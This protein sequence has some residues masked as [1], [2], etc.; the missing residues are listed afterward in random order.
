MKYTAVLIA[1]F[2]C[3]MLLLF[4]Q[5]AMKA[6][7]D[8]LN[9]WWGTLLPTLFPFFV[10]ATIIERTGG[11]H[12][13]A[14]ALYP[15]TRKLR[16]SPYA[17]P[18]L[19]FGG[20][21]GY[22]SGARLCGMLQNSGA[23]STNEAEQL[24]TICNLC[25]PMFLLGFVANGMFRD[26]KLFL[27]IALSHYCAALLVAALHKIL[28]PLS[29]SRPAST[30][31]NF[32]TS[33]IGTLPKAIADG[34]SDML[35]VGGSILFFF[36]LAELS[37]QL[38][39]FEILGYPIDL[40]FIGP[41]KSPPSYGI[42][43]GIMEITGGCYYISQ[44]GMPVQTAI[45]LCTFIV[46]FGGLSTMVQA[47]AFIQFK[48]PFRYVCIKLVHGLI[49]GLITHLYFTLFKY[50][51]PAFSATQE[52]SPYLVNALSGLS[53]LFAGSISIAFAM[54]LGIASNK[55]SKKT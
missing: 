47:M 27:P 51:M 52:I 28:W 32:K 18:I 38:G 55:P 36:V 40:L 3:L 33:F 17:L 6:A 24:G 45:T 37:K 31:F 34:M 12:S 39:L 54:L 9:L 10:S 4:T 15:V 2:L 49:A 21:S 7:Q 25:S 20:I 13:L 44:A 48:K 43:L 1:F 5:P 19:I 46:S 42:L 53:L 16:V 14:K 35:K 8:A 41:S 11:L 30:S 29:Y 26:A 50:S 22:P 23:I